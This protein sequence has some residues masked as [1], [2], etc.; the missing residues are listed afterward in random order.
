MSKADFD[1]HR[2]DP[3][4]IRLLTLARIVN[5]LDFCWRSFLESNKDNT[6]AGRRQYFNSLFFACGVLHEGL[7][8]A[9]TLGEHFKDRESFRAG[10]AR[11]LG[12]D[13]TRSLEASLDTLDKI[14]NKTVFH[15]DENEVK[16]V[17][18]DINFDSYVF[19]IGRG[20][21]YGEAYH[22][23]ADEVAFNI[24]FETGQS[25]NEE[26]ES[27]RGILSG[28]ATVARGFLK[29]ADELIADVVL[30]MGWRGHKSDNG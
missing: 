6:P 3:R 8:V 16:R 21:K 9:S 5:A 27:L 23:L 12:S 15:F 4:L 24:I 2:A 25:R 19:T 10:F 26:V 28:I 1:A 17:L 18:G 20:S 22:R 30:D 29:A 14:R 11:L 13:E 7:K